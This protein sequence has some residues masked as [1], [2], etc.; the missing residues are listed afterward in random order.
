[1]NRISY[2]AV[3]LWKKERHIG[4]I[5]EKTWKPNLTTSHWSHH[6]VSDNFEPSLKI[7]IFYHIGSLPQSQSESHNID[8]TIKYFQK[9]I[10]T[11]ERKRG[12]FGFLVI[13]RVLEI[14]IYYIK[15]G[16]GF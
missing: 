5:V 15:F 10:I 6:L 16:N 4:V 2:T 14:S 8:R 1:M 13:L 9:Q 7:N 11:T 12:T 3:I